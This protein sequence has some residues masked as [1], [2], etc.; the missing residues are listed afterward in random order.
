[1]LIC[2]SSN[3]I[4]RHLENSSV[5]TQTSII[6][7]LTRG[8]K[9][10]LDKTLLGVICLS[11]A[12]LALRRD[13]FF[14]LLLGWGRNDLLPQKITFPQGNYSTTSSNFF[15]NS[16]FGRLGGGLEVCGIGFLGVS[17]T[18]DAW[19]PFCPQFLPTP[20]VNSKAKENHIPLYIYLKS[21]F[22]QSLFLA[23]KKE[24]L[25]GCLWVW[26]RKSD[27]RYNSSISYL[28]WTVLVL[29]YILFHSNRIKVSTSMPRSW[30]YCQA[31]LA[32]S[33]GSVTKV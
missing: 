24:L 4:L 2:Y 19:L 15:T 8:A 11:L 12:H 7:H 21:S 9:F 29:Q 20:L 28:W 18:I 27:L 25:S 10:P 5:P 13:T 23:F 17:D 14:S 6:G 26:V 30:V 32:A 31:F 33:W 16:A 22:G 3:R 1:M